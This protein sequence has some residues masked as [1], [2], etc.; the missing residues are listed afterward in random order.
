METTQNSKERLQFYGGP[1][2]PLLVFVPIILYIIVAIYLNVVVKKMDFYAIAGAALGGLILIS[3]FSKDQAK[4]WNAVIKGAGT[5]V[6]IYVAFMMMV[7]GIFAYAIR[8][9]DLTGG[10]V[11]LG[12]RLGLSGALFTVFTFLATSIISSG[13]GSSY[14]ALFTC[15]P[16]FYPA[17]V[18]LGG[19]P[20][21]V[22]GAIYCASHLGDNLAPVSDTTILSATTQFYKNSDQCADIPGCVATRFK[23]VLVASVISIVYYYIRGGGYECDAAVEEYIAGV[24]PV[25]LVMIVPVLLTLYIAFKKREVFVATGIGTIFSIIVALAFKLIT[26]KDIFNINPETGACQGLL[27][28]GFS[29]MLGVVIIILVMLGVMNVIREAGV[30]DSICEKISRS[31]LCN[32]AAGTEF[33]LAML[34]SFLSGIMGCSQDPCLIM[35]GPV[36]DEL[37]QKANIHP[38][39]RAEIIDAMSTMLPACIPFTC[40]YLFVAASMTAGYS[41]VAPLTPFDIVPGMIYCFTL[42]CLFMVSI[43]T[44]WG[45]LYEGPNGEPLKGDGT[46]LKNLWT[47][48]FIAKNRRCDDPIKKV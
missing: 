47:L 3:M 41:F 35:L 22:A 4:F 39:R 2:V 6:G 25:S 30:F 10:L 44:G 38:Y 21:I 9:A 33:T 40:K 20:G 45:R 11:W 19:N 12:T 23:Y 24:T 7:V 36:Y 29:G 14:A 5:H 17:A 13:T 43:I 32:T 27:Y 18:A 34:M 48:F 42:F 37:G 26:F 15:F 8:Y 46:Q 31:K 28:E 16:I 1:V